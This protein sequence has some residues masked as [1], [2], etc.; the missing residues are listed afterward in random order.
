MTIFNRAGTRTI[1]DEVTSKGEIIFY[2]RR[3]VGGGIQNFEAM[4]LLKIEA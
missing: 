1:R 3:R 4:K 2:S